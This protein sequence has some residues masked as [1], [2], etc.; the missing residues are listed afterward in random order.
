MYTWTAAKDYNDG[1]L[2]DPDGADANLLTWNHV[3]WESDWNTGD[4][5]TAI[6]SNP[7]IPGSDEYTWTTQGLKVSADAKAADVEKVNVFPNPYYAYNPSEVDRYNRFV[8]FNNLPSKATFRIFN[9]A[10]AQVRKL[11]KNDNSQFFKWDLLNESRLPVASGMYIVYV[12]MPDVGKQKVL[13][14]FIVQPKEVLQ[15]Y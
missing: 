3:W 12:D 2:L 8:T 10:G 5:V 14:L 11:E 9:L 6:Y 1:A 4:K 15:Y 7:V 13:K